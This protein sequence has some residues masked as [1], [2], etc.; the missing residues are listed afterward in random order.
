MDRPTPIMNT[1]NKPTS[2]E[3]S[4]KEKVYINSLGWEC[5][6]NKKNMYYWK[7]FTYRCDTLFPLVEILT[8]LQEYCNGQHTGPSDTSF[9]CKSVTEEP[10]EII[11]CDLVLI[12]QGSDNST[13]F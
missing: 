11:H 7:D 2:C 13:V 9:E 3:F 4:I 1:S 6:I 5:I 10:T 12:Q 8:I